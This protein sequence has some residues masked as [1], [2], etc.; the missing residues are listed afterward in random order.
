MHALSELIQITFAPR[1]GEPG[2]AWRLQLPET[3]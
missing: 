3:T 1:R 2:R